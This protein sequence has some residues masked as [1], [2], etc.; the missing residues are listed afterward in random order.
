[1]KRALAVVCLLFLAVSV[2]A[3]MAPMPKPE[4]YLIHEEVA[5]P[6]MLAQYEATTREFLNMLTEHKIDPKVMGMNL[7]TTTDMHYLYVV[8]IASFGGVDAINQTF[9]TMGQTVGKDRWADLS[10]R[11]NMTI[12]A[13][14]EY[15]ALRRPD[16][17]YAPATPR[18]RLEERRFVPW[19]FYYIDAAHTDEAE[20]VAKDYVALFKSK[21]IGDSFSVY[22]VMSGNDLP[23]YVAAAAGKSAAD[24]YSNDERINSMLGADVRPLQARVLSYTRKYEVKDGTARPE[25]SYPMPAAT[26]VPK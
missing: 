22:Q 17:S 5:R 10:R 6:G 9:A 25:L 13:Y 12:S 20:Q 3:Q 19:Q 11:G 8:P 7:Y 18:L 26:S 2:S 21:N 15:V 24:F 16:L 1:M 4:Y 23:L 14:N